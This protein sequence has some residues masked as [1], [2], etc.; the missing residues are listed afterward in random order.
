VALH[1]LYGTPPT[2]VLEWL[3]GAPL[4]AHMSAGRLE[5]ARA[6]RVVAELLQALDTAHAVDVVHGDL[7]PENLWIEPAGN[8]K[9]F[10]F[11]ATPRAGGDTTAMYAAPEV[12]CGGAPGPG[13]DLYAAASIAFEI[14]SGRPPFDGTDAHELGR[15]KASTPA[16]SVRAAG[17]DA[18]E[19]MEEWFRRAL[20]RDPRGRFVSVAEAER[21]WTGLA[22]AGAGPRPRLTLQPYA[23]AQLVSLWRDGRLVPGACVCVVGAAGFGKTHLLR[24]LVAAH[25]GAARVQAWFEG[26]D[27]DALETAIG[28]LLSAARHDP[29]LLV[30]DAF[31][32]LD[33]ASQQQLLRVVQRATVLGL[34]VVVAANPLRMDPEAA[35]RWCA[36]VD[37]SSQQVHLRRPDLDGVRGLVAER[38]RTQSISDSLAALVHERSGANPRYALGIVDWLCSSGSL[39]AA[40]ET[41]TFDPARCAD[42]VPPTLVPFLQTTL[43]LVPAPTRALLREAALY[44]VRFQAALVAERLGLPAADAEGRLH[45]LACRPT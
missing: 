11:G 31:E 20:A 18:P 34:T 15:R 12:L 32:L 41:W 14:L 22:V 19:S 2:L 37:A 3:E 4:R 16:P 42:D 17:G 1:D 33:A 39:R 10:D 24:E 8:V 7:K 40:G 35:A 43:E 30:V 9:L 45:D 6:H 13:A 38:L 27:A 36:V 23:H 44:G 5:V 28:T 26:A 21:A 29:K 25:G